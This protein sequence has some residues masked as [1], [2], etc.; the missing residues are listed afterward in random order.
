MAPI[1][2]VNEA[3]SEPIAGRLIISFEEK[4][5]NEQRMTENDNIMRMFPIVLRI[6]RTC[7]SRMKFRRISGTR[8]R[9]R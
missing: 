2:M 1:P 9:H 4:I 6:A 3:K 7:S 8:Q 5:S